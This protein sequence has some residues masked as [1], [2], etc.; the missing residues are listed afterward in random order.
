MYIENE[1]RE[2]GKGKETIMKT[3]TSKIIYY[4]PVFSVQWREFPQKENVYF[5]SDDEEHF[6]F[7]ESE[8]TVRY[9]EEDFTLGEAIADSVERFK[10]LKNSCSW[11]EFSDLRVERREVSVVTKEE[12]VWR[13]K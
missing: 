2:K 9:Y 7:E 6:T 1:K 3:I 8:A 10:M 5:F 12:E 4:I 13:A 11:Y